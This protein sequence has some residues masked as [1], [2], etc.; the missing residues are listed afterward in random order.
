M[1]KLFI[2][3]NHQNVKDFSKVLDRTWS[4]QWAFSLTVGSPPRR[5]SR[6]TC[7]DMVTSRPTHLSLM[8]HATMSSGEPSAHQ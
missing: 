5:A 6:V 1:P 7:C 3:Q 8:M 2:S 4:A